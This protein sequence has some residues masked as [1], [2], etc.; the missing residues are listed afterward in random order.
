MVSFKTETNTLSSRIISGEFPAFKE[1]F[2]SQYKYIATLDREEL[3]TSLDRVSVMAD[4]KKHLIRMHFEGDTM[5]I[6]ANTPDF[7]GAQDEVAMKFEGQVLDVAVN[8][9]YLIDVL[10]CLSSAKI[11]IEMTGSLQPLIIKEVGSES[12]K[13]LLMPV[14]LKTGE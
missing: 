5:Q 14:Q 3:L 7:G 2:P 8:A 13:Y 1:L 4:E 12:Y 6:T 10:R 9:R 11:Q